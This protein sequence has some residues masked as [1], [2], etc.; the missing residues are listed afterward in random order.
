MFEHRAFREKCTVLKKI[1]ATLLGLFGARVILPPLPTLGTL[2]SE[3]HVH[4]ID[5]VYGRKFKLKH[6]KKIDDAMALFHLDYLYATMTRL[7]RVSSL[8][9]PSFKKISP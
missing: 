1:L 2:L 8:H 7:G 6:S 9:W 5:R 3:M 4:P